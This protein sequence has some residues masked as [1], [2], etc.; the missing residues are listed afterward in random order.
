M[1]KT[2]KNDLF[3]KLNNYL[4]VLFK[5]IIKQLR[6]RMLFFDKKIYLFK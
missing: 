1:L 2:F 6:V 3:F 4:S 5:A